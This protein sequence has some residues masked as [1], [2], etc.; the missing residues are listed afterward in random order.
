MRFF[1]YDIT[2]AKDADK[3][4]AQ[5]VRLNP[6]FSTLGIGPEEINTQSMFGQAKAYSACSVLMSVIA[7]KVGAM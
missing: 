4:A 2:K 7:K 6:L 5:S 1:G 3:I